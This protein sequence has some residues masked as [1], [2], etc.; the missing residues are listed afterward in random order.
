MPG[1]SGC[2][3]MPDQGGSRGVAPETSAWSSSQDLTPF[4]N[5]SS[6]SSRNGAEG[7]DPCPGEGDHDGEEDSRDCWDGENSNLIRR[8]KCVCGCV[9]LDCQKALKC[10]IGIAEKA[11]GYDC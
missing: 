2:S 11:V 3:L 4:G 10:R 8:A 5:H 9:G 1:Q 7:V 6:Q